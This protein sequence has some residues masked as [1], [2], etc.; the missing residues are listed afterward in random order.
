MILYHESKVPLSIWLF[1]TTI[2]KQSQLGKD[3]N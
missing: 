1:I 3:I 2:F